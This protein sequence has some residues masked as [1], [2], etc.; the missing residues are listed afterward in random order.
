[1]VTLEDTGYIRSHAATSLSTGRTGLLG[2]VIGANRNPTVLSAI[3]G[4]LSM[5]SG[6]ELVIYV[7]ETDDGHDT[8]YRRLR[9]SRAVDGVV[10]LFPRLADEPTIRAL[11]RAGVP[12]VLVE[13]QAPVDGASMVW[14]DSYHDGYVSTAHLVALGHTRIAICADTPG[15]GRERRYVEGY[16]DAL[17]DASIDD[18]AELIAQTGWTHDAG[19]EATSRWLAFDDP[20]TAACYCCD[21]AAFGA[22]ACARDRRL[23]LPED[24][25]I[26][27][28][29]DTE[30]ASWVVP[31]LTALRD[32]RTALVAE[33][34]PDPHRDVGR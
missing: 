29:D 12:V 8:I 30:V 23:R 18:D 26:V 9:A 2:L 34:F 24:L 16:R 10:H 13:P 25:A 17:A 14:P 27:G 1:M 6:H 5:G 31:A 19:Y 3:H 15:W 33:A 21:T 32:R 11:Q 7:S 20:P 4:A 28:Y 22:M